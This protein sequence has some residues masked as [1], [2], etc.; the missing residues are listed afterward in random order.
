MPI[1]LK[2]PAAPLGAL[3]AGWL[4]V[5]VHA[6][7]GIGGHGID[8][9]LEQDL[10]D[11]L[12]VAAAV[13]IVARALLQSEERVP[14]LIFGGGALLW[15]VHHIPATTHPATATPSPFDAGYL[16]FYA[17]MFCSLLLLLRA[18]VRGLRHD[19]LLDGLL[20][21][22][23]SVAV[24]A[25][26]AQPLVDSI[27][28][29]NS[30]LSADFSHPVLDLLLL[31]VA[32]T[33]VAIN[34]WR[35]TRVWLL[36]AGGL[37]AFTAADILFLYEKATGNLT[38]NAWTA[39]LWLGSFILLAMSAWQSRRV[40][41]T[42]DRAARG[43][44]V[45]VAAMLAA[46]AVLVDGDLQSLYPPAIGLAVVSLL[47]A[48][49]RTWLMLRENANMLTLVRRQAGT[50]PLTGL[51]NRRSLF[52]D[53]DR[54][55][56]AATKAKPLLLVYYDLD[57]FK[58]YND[59]FGHLAGDA[60]LNRLGGQLA[61]AIGGHGRAYRVGGDEF[62]ALL[63]CPAEIEESIVASSV[64][65]LSERGAGFDVTT[66]HGAVR[67][68]VEAKDSFSALQLADQRLYKHKEVR[69]GSAKH[70]LR[71]VL[72][73]A[74]E[75]REPALGEHHRSVAELA[76]QVARRLRL[77]NDQLDLIAAAA[78]LHD[79][80]KM[81]IPDSILEKPGPLDAEEWARMREHT[82]LGERILAAAPAL[83]PVA[84]LVRSSHERFDGF[85]YPDGLS[86]EQ[87]PIGSRVVAVCD[88][89]HAMTA[90]RAYRRGMDP[91]EAVAR[92]RRAAGTQFDPRVVD[93]FIDVIRT[94]LP[95]AANAPAHG[96]HA[97]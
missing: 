64:E 93:A 3:G 8:V 62:C 81:A 25:A 74:F 1:R 51:G 42:V 83:R 39:V 18:R 6:A 94:E 78:E 45:P 24:T 23:A 40:V 68:P 82:V 96:Q 44:F 43:F 12:C 60:L 59:T 52:E 15:A 28:H 63:R 88:A 41:A 27:S 95:A 66:S 34:G 86:G 56:R 89:Y 48:G 87:I 61:Q 85:G 2:S 7:T 47:T 65:A 84:A 77:P 67:V 31:T 71:D 76:V 73:Q 92:L 22:T 91:R 4:I 10:A 20:A 30:A 13:V 35:L 29:N 33:A 5:A 9:Y 37:L 19:L 26:L 53:V 49:L 11:A 21:G 97:A 80:G 72:L 17:A 75:A 16:A 50:D 54:D 58:Q 14:W 46:V 69:P 57:G 38:S 32:V 55:V 36:I 90:D 70:Q 79:V